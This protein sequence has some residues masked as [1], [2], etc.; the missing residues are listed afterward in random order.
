LEDQVLLLQSGVVGQSLF[1]GDLDQLRHGHLLQLAD[2]RTAALDLLVAGV[3]LLVEAGVVVFVEG[4][5]RTGAR[6]LARC[7]REISR[8]TRTLRFLFG[9]LAVGRAIGFADPRP[10]AGRTA[11]GFSHG[12]SSPTFVRGWRQKTGGER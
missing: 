7:G 8:R 4:A 2:V 6:P 11:L 12:W 5:L 10:D 1:L 3:D 9:G